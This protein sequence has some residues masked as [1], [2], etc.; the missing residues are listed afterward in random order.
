MSDDKSTKESETTEVKTEGVTASEPKKESE[1][2]VKGDEPMTEVK[3]E[4]DAKTAE[5]DRKKKEE[6]KKKYANWPL[7][8]I[9]DPHENDV[10]YGRGGG[11]NHHS[12]N[13]QYRKMVEDRKLEYVNSKRLDKP[14]VALE[15]IRIW[16]GQVPPG[17]FLKLDEKT[18]LWNDVGDKKAREKTSQALREKAPLIRKQQEDEKGED[19]KSPKAADAKVTRFAAGTKTESSKAEK[20]VLARDHSL[21][22][23]YLQDGEAVSVEGFSWR[24]PFLADSGK[25]TPSFGSAAS[26]MAA[27][28]APGAYPPAGRHSSSGSLG[29]APPHHGGPPPPPDYYGRVGSN[30]LREYS[31]GRIESWGSFPYPPP[32]PPPAVHGLTHQ[33]SGSWTYNQTPPP[34]MPGHQRSGSWGGREHSLAFNPL[35]GASV[36]LPADQRAFEPR[37][38]PPQQYWATGQYRS[39]PRQLSPANSTPSPKPTYNVNMDIAR[40]WSGGAEG[41]PRPGW[42]DQQNKPMAYSQ[43]VPVP[44]AGDISPMRNNAGYMPKPQMVKR[45]TSHQAESSET[46][47][48]VKRAALNRDNSMA[49][50]RLKAQYMPEYYNGQFNSDHEVKKLSDNLEQSQLS[51]KRSEPP[52][53]P[54][55]ESLKDSN[56]LTTLD[57]NELMAKPEPLSTRTTTMEALGIDLE[58]EPMF[59]SPIE[60]GSNIPRPNVMTTDNRLTT[61]EIYDLVNADPADLVKGSDG[62]PPLNQESVADNWL[63]QS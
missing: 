45:D 15:I 11:T 27:P 41:N 56:R 39:P 31:T 40:T 30:Q 51:P 53:A 29:I 28:A 46:K 55:P 24:D 63:T 18:G 22:R 35:I 52:V 47:H 61:T 37:P 43:P 48:Q 17:R 2:S 1:A 62:P 32:P 9:K 60:G 38:G 5:E 59:D 50:N 57:I 34:A 4:E 3:K 12:G 14:L 44:G 54:K 33:R 19:E 26:P 13:K 7:K 36:A 16:R 58:N 49:S 42:V 8:G 6:L 10:M 21:G 20:P 23:E 25:R